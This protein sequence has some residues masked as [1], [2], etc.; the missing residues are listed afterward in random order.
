MP[1]ISIRVV[2]EYL[3]FFL[4]IF[5]FNFLKELEEQYFNKFK[6]INKNDFLTNSHNY[7]V[8]Y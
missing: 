2:I 5:L 7:N 1:A 3:L 6:F 8:S 4:M